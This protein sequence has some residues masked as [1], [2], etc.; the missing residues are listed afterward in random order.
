[1]NIQHPFLRKVVGTLWYSLATLL[2]LAALLVTAARV[3]LPYVEGYRQEVEQ[4]VS[5]RTGQPVRIGKMKA[6]WRGFTPYLVFS[7]IDL[8]DDKSEKALLHFSG[9][10]IGVHL[11]HS[12]YQWQVVTSNLTVTGLQLQITRFTD[13]HIEIRGLSARAQATTDTDSAVVARWLFSQPDIGIA[14]SQLAWTDKLNKHSTLNFSDVRLRLRNDKDRHQLDGDIR[15]PDDYGKS[16]GFALDIQGDVL[17]PRD[18][19]GSLYIKGKKLHPQSMSGPLT[20]ADLSLNAASIDM[21]IWSEWRKSKLTSLDGSLLLDDIKLQVGGQAS[22]LRKIQFDLNWLRKEQGWG[23]RVSDI[24]IKSDRDWPVTQLILNKKEAEAAYDLQLSFLHLDDV[25]P[26][27]ASSGLL[28]DLSAQLMAMQPKGDMHDIHLRVAPGGKFSIA[29]RFQAVSVKP[30]MQI[31]GIG[32]LSGELS[33]TEDK[34]KFDIAS[35]LFS[36]TAPSV[37][38]DSLVFDKFSA[39]STW[40]R[41]ELGLHI[42]VPALQLSNA[43]MSSE[44]HMQLDIPADGGSPVIDITTSLKGQ[45]GEHMSA[46]LP[47]G[48]MSKEVITWLDNAIKAGTV[49]EGSFLLR[50]PIRK[51]PFKDKEGRFE[52]GFKVVNGILNYQQGWPMIHDIEADVLFDGPGLL[53]KSNKGRIYD[54]PLQAIEVRIPDID[55][56]IP[57]L[58]FKGDSLGGTADALKFLLESKIAGERQKGLQQLKVT[59]NTHVSLAMNIPLDESV[60]SDI[61]GSFTLE[62]SAISVKNSAHALEHINGKVTFKNSNFSS[63]NIKASLFDKPLAIEVDSHIKGD[64]NLP[65]AAIRISGRGQLDLN[66][67]LRSKIDKNIP[68]LVDGED[69]WQVT[70]RIPENTRKDVRWS[71]SSRLR[72]SVVAL[73]EPFI[74]AKGEERLFKLAGTLPNEKAMQIWLYYGSVFNGVIRADTSKHFMPERGELQFGDVTASLPDQA[75]IVVRGGVKEL[76]VSAWQNWLGLQG[77]TRKAKSEFFPIRDVNV[78]LGVLNYRQH[79]LQ[80]VHIK[81]SRGENEW[82]VDAESDRITGRISIPHEQAQLPIR[83]D[84]EKLDL[85]KVA[86]SGEKSETDPR[87]LPALQMQVKQFVYD[88]KDFGALEIVLVPQLMGS[89]I[90]KLRIDSPM[91]LVEATGDWQIDEKQQQITR[92]NAKLHS[93]DLGLLFKQLGYADAVKSSRSKAS[94]QL[95]WAGGPTDFSVND[96]AGTMKIDLRKGQLV[97]IEPGA[98][99]VFGLLSV[100]TLSR[101]LTLDFSDL[102]SKG[103]SFDV[104]KGNF[105]FDKGNAYTTD[106]YFDG[107][108]ARIDASG[109]VGMK[110]EDYD[111][112]VTVTPKL[113]ASLPIA[114]ALV[115]GPIAGGVL[116]AVE[117]LFGRSIDQ[118]SQ[119]QYSMAGSWEQPIVTPLLKEP[120]AVATEAETKVGPRP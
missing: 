63:H 48:I 29:S 82:Q 93:N 111:Q 52:I 102:F 95:Q 97:D 103:F 7:D 116:F 59:G 45:N 112:M 85:P 96:L 109:R 42:D 36:F 119:S 15:L 72:D 67:L 39:K 19:E 69:S 17:R 40:T 30:W 28:K 104:I 5:E 91:L 2:V 44:G 113:T 89:F 110:N 38:R 1:M 120:K 13:S 26:V 64:A 80:N 106:L 22:A 55:I 87:K 61:D 101:R 50:G 92:L 31:P 68:L 8:L 4:A 57:V 62:E 74:K 84:L 115:G 99:R 35:D 53:I 51:F 77:D 100:A 49:P 23:V 43:D 118:I 37:F 83:I 88:G 47:A 25:V 56:K 58:S 65:D 98:G 24:K 21:E 90:E 33:G 76:S 107:P 12:L 46:Y 11:W 14:N 75:G 41:D 20:V 117:K 86:E 114:G 9:A 16:L 34:G 71:V 10:S 105:T 18:W 54:T 70:L 73:P 27:L 32:N 6:E 108:A 66:E 81:A 79:R 60:E 78:T 94:A 3:L